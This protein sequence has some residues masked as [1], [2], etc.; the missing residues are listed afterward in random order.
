VTSPPPSEAERILPPATEPDT[1]P[2]SHKADEEKTRPAAQPA[3][4]ANEDDDKDAG[5]G[6]ILQELRQLKESADQ[7]ISEGLYWKAAE[8]YESMQSWS[9]AAELWQLINQ[10]D[11]AAAALSQHAQIVSKRDVN[12][13]EKVEAWQ[14]AA[15]AYIT[16]N[17][18]VEAARI[19]HEQLDDSELAAE[20]YLASGEFTLAAELNKEWTHIEQILTVLQT[21][22]DE[23]GPIYL[24][25]DIPF[26]KLHNS[27]EAC[28][29]SE[30]DRV[31]ALCDLTFFGSAKKC[32]LFTVDTFHYNSDRGSGA[33]PYS[34]FPQRVFADL[35]NYDVSLGEDPA[36]GQIQ[37]T[38]IT[39][40]SAAWTQL[41]QNIQAL[42]A[43]AQSQDSLEEDTKIDRVKEPAPVSQLNLD[44][45]TFVHEETGLEFVR[46]PAGEFLYG[47]EKEPVYLETFWISKTPVTNNV[48][49]LFIDA[50][51]EHRLPRAFLGMNNWN[52]KDRSYPDGL[53]E[54]PVIQVSWDDAVAFCR[55]AGV[56]L[57]TEQ[58]W[59]KAARGT[60][61]RHYPWGNQWEDGRC[62][63]REAGIGI[64]SLVG[65]FSPAGDS[66]YGCV[67]MC[68][69]AWEWCLNN[70]AEPDNIE[71]DISNILRM[72]RGG[73]WLN[74][75]N[76]VNVTASR[77]FIP[78]HRNSDLGFRVVLTL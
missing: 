48:Y 49:K 20:L 63:T 11:K 12:E 31:L 25:P 73:S 64:V 4:Q 30:Y 14:Q 24:F 33:I 21:F 18:P 55:W 76:E 50:N 40:N 34:E 65:Q 59:E 74:N 70:E 58:Q 6:D 19:W 43:P 71:I 46:I 36:T 15:Q 68:G 45:E 56:S 78:G 1:V 17:Q 29:L 41:L 37:Q 69:N 23:H 62:N 51:P 10:Y 53:A 72:M 60:D 52:K 66:P 8:I 47:E 27:I 13:K 42:F 7:Y 35:R 57:P 61:G 3:E 16:A 32:L 75:A 54:H 22:Q 44:G 26:E 9:Y 77:E 28:Q 39:G 38:A 67:D 2:I 5:T